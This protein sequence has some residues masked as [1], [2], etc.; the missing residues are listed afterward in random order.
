MLIANV[1]CYGA[2]VLPLEDALRATYTACVG[3]DGELAD[4]KKMAGINTAVTAVGT[5]LGIGA[6][7][8]GL[9]KANTDSILAQKYKEMEDLSYAAPTYVDTVDTEE[10]LVAAKAAINNSLEKESFDGIFKDYEK[11]GG[12]GFMHSTVR[13]DMDKLRVIPMYATAEIISLMQSRR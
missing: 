11:L 6:V 1:N 10:F 5:G 4:L 12:N 13:P 8:T 9:A 7:A 2:D 3:I